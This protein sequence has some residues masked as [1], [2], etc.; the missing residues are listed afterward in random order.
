MNGR[1]GTDDRSILRGP[2]RPSVHS[3][4]WL[5]Q[6]VA[7]HGEHAQRPHTYQRAARADD[8]E[9]VIFRARSFAGRLQV[10]TTTLGLLTLEEPGPNPAEPARSRFPAALPS[11]H[12]IGRFLRHNGPALNGRAGTRP[13][14]IK[15]DRSARPV[16]SS[17]GLSRSRAAA[18]TLRPPIRSNHPG[19][20][21]CHFN[22]FESF[23]RILVIRR[24]LNRLPETI[25]RLGPPGLPRGAQATSYDRL[26]P[27]SLV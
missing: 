21:Y 5:S 25:C 23:N 9:T 10:P 13:L 19:K 16:R 18:S 24:D 2:F 27:T 8:N 11:R 14:S 17:A 4:A 3:S 15:K 12:T 20:R 26:H 6:P 7:R 1:P 22:V